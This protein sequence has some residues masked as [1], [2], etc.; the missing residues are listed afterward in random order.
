M[1]KR[2]PRTHTPCLPSKRV[3]RIDDAIRPLRPQADLK[4]DVRKS[5]FSAVIAEAS[6]RTNWPK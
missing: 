5:G 1:S 4:A 3:R 6:E 2:L